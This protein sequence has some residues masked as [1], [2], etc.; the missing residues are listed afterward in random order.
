MS[1][2]LCKFV[3]T[4]T[5]LTATLLL[6]ACG[7]GDGGDDG[8]TPSVARD[9]FVAMASSSSCANL[10]NQLFVIDEQMVFWDKAGTCADAGY[11][12]I[13]FGATPQQELCSRMDSI[14]G[15]RQH[16]P[17]T[18]HAS[19]F[20]TITQNLDK[21]DLGLGAGH[22][23]E[24]LNVP[25]GPST[26][27]HFS[28]T[29]SQLYRGTAPAHIVIRDAAAWS[30]FWRDQAQSGTPLYPEPD[31]ARQMVVGVFSS[32]AN[33]CNQTRIARLSSDGQALNVE[34]LDMHITTVQACGPTPGTPMSLALVDTSP[35][36]VRFESIGAKLVPVNLIAQSDQSGFTSPLT[37]VV[38]DATRWAAVWTQYASKQQPPPAQPHIDF[39]QRMV[40]VIARG[41]RASGCETMRDLTVWRSGGRLHIA[42]YDLIP[43]PATV[44]AAV[45]T[46]PA[47]LL[48]LERSADPVEFIGIPTPI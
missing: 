40:A 30:S 25:P 23:I 42:H 4:T 17:Q 43:G 8:E 27:L 26:T 35:L 22:R 24:R 45:T 20:A 37:E 16:C 38:N 21:P 9:A 36:P 3:T 34:Y 41:Q 28:L 14:A 31:F 7:G 46:H 6:G 1:T 44:C 48:D 15:P 2:R 18:Q 5:L 13:L 11:A 33:P 47:A 39:G 32:V 12:Q 10:R 19:L 29:N